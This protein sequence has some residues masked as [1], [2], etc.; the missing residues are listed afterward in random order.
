VVLQAGNDGKLLAREAGEN[1]APVLIGGKFGS[2]KV[3]L[4]GALLGYA[5]DG[6]LDEG[7]RRLLLELC[8]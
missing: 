8:K 5:P 4:Y 7:E 2:G 6:E 1:G 3:F